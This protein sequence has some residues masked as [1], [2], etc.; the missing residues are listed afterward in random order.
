MGILIGVAAIASL[1]WLGI[2]AYNNIN[3]SGVPIST[4]QQPGA[5]TAF[6]VARPNFI[7]DGSELSR[8]E[9]WAVPVS[10]KEISE[11]DY[12]LIGNAM[13]Q[14]GAEDPLIQIWTLPIPKESI[15]AT[16]IFAKGFDMK[17]EFVGQMSL[18]YLGA[19]QI[20]NA[21]WSGPAPVATSSAPDTQRHFSFALR[22]GESTTVGG[23]TVKLIEIESDSRCP[24]TAVCIWAGEVAAKVQ[25]TSANRNE[26]VTLH[27]MSAVSTFGD[28]QIGITGV[29]P[30]RQ[31]TAPAKSEYHL[32][33]SVE[34][35]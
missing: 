34:K 6:L 7:V 4:Q 32:T 11:S 25:L 3:I 22:V 33:F 9:I 14:S 5:V 10:S 17:G 13:L 12:Q 21:I 18:P 15:A 1:L 19:T 2:Y 30:A 27:S 20:F 23:L 29:S 8:V 16:E 24:R 26:A 35:M 31:R 28:Y